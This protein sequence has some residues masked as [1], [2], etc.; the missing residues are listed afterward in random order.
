MAFQF[1]KKE[2]LKEIIEYLKRIMLV[3]HRFCASIFIATAFLLGST[4]LNLGL[5]NKYHGLS[6][7]VESSHLWLSPYLS[8]YEDDISINLESE[9]FEIKKDQYLYSELSTEYFD[10]TQV[11]LKPSV[12]LGRINTF[13]IFQFYRPPPVSV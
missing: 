13:P 1:R 12:E 7:N 11:L 2:Y 4:E 6:E 8:F 3:F 5:T 9:E 10:L